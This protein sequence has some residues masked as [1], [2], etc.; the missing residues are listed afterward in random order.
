MAT[1]SEPLVLLHME[2]SERRARLAVFAEE[3][4]LRA[5]LRIPEQRPQQCPAAACT[6]VLRVAAVNQPDPETKKPS[7]VLHVPLAQTRGRGRAAAGS[8]RG[9]G[10]APAGYSGRGKGV[11]PPASRSR[12]PTPPKGPETMRRP[13][14]PSVAVVPVAADQPAETRRPVTPPAVTAE[15]ADDAAPAAAAVAAEQPVPPRLLAARRHTGSYM[16]VKTMWGLCIRVPCTVTDTVRQ[17]KRGIEIIQ[18]I[19][20]D[21]QRLLFNLAEL[22]DD[23]V[24]LGELGASPCPPP[25]DSQS[26]SDHWQRGRGGTLAAVGGQVLHLVLHPQKHGD[27]A[28]GGVEGKA[29][30]AAVEQEEAKQRSLTRFDDAELLAEIDT[31]IAVAESEGLPTGR[32]RRRRA[33]LE[34]RIAAEAAHEV[35]QPSLDGEAAGEFE[36]WMHGA[37]SQHTAARTYDSLVPADALGEE[38]DSDEELMKYSGRLKKRGPAGDDPYF[39]KDGRTFRLNNVAVVDWKRKEIDRKAIDWDKDKNTSTLNPGQGEGVRLGHASLRPWAE[40]MDW[41]KDAPLLT[42][43]QMLGSRFLWIPASTVSL[44]VYDNPGMTVAE[45]DKLLSYLSIEAIEENCGRVEL[46]GPP[47]LPPPLPRLDED[48]A[49]DDATSVCWSTAT[50]RRRKKRTIQGGVSAHGAPRSPPGWHR[51]R[52][53]AA[54]AAVHRSLAASTAVELIPGVVL[55]KGMMDI[56]TQQWMVDE[57]FRLGTNQPGLSGGFFRVMETGF[58]ELNMG[59][60][61]SF[62]QDLRSFAPHFSEVAEHYQ[63][64]ALAHADAAKHLPQTRPHWCAFNLYSAR[65]PGIA[66]HRDGDETRARIQARRGR[67]VISLT[68][69]LSCEFRFKNHQTEDDHVV[70]LDSGDVLIFGGPSR[71]MLHAVTRIHGGTIPKM[72]HWPYPEARLNL[73][74]RHRN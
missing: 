36:L 48:A 10:V 21:Q 15:L 38:T 1:V 24:V 32:L 23:D 37:G 71:N 59:H 72:L 20:V 39:H 30:R 63:R 5:A 43:R 31:E 69:G 28:S 35:L 12:S 13:V 54:E 40:R 66:W 14:A 11:V 9:Q 55:M 29:R 3:K 16:Y 7:G 49:D 42:K 17:V 8:G 44:V 18:N 45:L 19:P 68:L 67:P 46:P 47:R 33:A 52:G 74:Y 58:T 22:M 51:D 57:T 25:D 34:H 73:T 60:R 56:K 62:G 27:P 26:E 65:S 4:A 50:S 61:G 53:V 2:A 70:R 41:D 64:H 6:A